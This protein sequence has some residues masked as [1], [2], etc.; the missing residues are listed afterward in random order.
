MRNLGEGVAHSN[1]ATPLF[2]NPDATV[3]VAVD[4]H[5]NSSFLLHW[6]GKKGGRIDLLPL[7]SSQI[8][9]RKVR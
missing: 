1:S 4:C 3:S 9:D 7:C 5:L 6:Y 2:R 8:P